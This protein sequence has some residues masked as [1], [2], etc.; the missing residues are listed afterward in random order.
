MVVGCVLAW[1]NVSAGPFWCDYKIGSYMIRCEC[2]PFWAEPF[3]HEGLVPC[4]VEYKC[5][6]FL[7][8]VVRCKCRGFQHGGLVPHMTECKCWAFPTLVD[9][10]ECWAF[11]TGLWEVFPH[12][13]MWVLGVPF[14]YDYRIGSYMIKYKCWVGH[15][16]LGSD[17]SV[18]RRP[19]WR[20]G[21]QPTWKRDGSVELHVTRRIMR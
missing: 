20:L 8:L 14:W 16:D 9:G 18:R 6:S 13:Q 1:L 12:G 5:W 10:C 15:S 17:I 3:R 21:L 4:M 11:L 2:M 19:T 7:T